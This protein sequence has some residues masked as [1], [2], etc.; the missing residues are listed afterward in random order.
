M[1]E[2]VLNVV[3]EVV[4]KSHC[5]HEEVGCKVVGGYFGIYVGCCVLGIVASSVRGASEAC[6]ICHCSRSGVFD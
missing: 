4:K 3:S 5:C 6:V 2:C 1:S